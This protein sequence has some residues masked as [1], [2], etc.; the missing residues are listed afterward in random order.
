ML[1]GRFNSGRNHIEARMAHDNEE[2][3]GMGWG[4]MGWGGMGLVVGLR[5]DGVE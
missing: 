2:W 4:G 3:G 5:W 1:L